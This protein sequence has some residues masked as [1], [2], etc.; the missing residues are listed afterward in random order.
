MDILEDVAQNHYALLKRVL[1]F[2]FRFYVTKKVGIEE[3][4]PNV[5]VS[6]TITNKKKKN[7]KT[8]YICS[9]LSYLYFAILLLFKK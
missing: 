8:R 3:L 9:G 7:R 2:R 4:T 6:L 1:F 5:K